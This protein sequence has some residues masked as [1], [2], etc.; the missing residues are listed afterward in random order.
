MF[1]ALMHG[2]HTNLVSACCE[3]RKR[4]SASLKAKSFALFEFVEEIAEAVT[5]TGDKAQKLIGLLRAAVCC[6]R[7]RFRSLRTIG[8]AGQ[9]P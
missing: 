3:T 2:T 8:T 6:R 5:W 4:S 7:M 9:L 1:P